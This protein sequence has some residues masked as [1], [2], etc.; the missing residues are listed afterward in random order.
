[1]AKQAALAVQGKPGL[2]QRVQTFWGEVRTEL[3]KVTWPSWADLQVST[4]VTMI[5]L[6]IMA[7][8]IFCFDWVFQKAVLLLLQWAA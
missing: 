5:L 2:I 1:M 6:G 3:S 7:V 4:N 8:I